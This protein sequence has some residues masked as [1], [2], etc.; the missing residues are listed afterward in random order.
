MCGLLQREDVRLLTLTGPGGTGKTRMG[1]QVAANL[2]EDFE[3]GVY[4]VPLAAINDP[5][6]VVS[7]IAQVL[8]IREKAGQ[9][10][11]DSLKEYLQAKQILLVLDNFEQVVAAAPLVAELLATCRRLPALVTSRVVLRLSGEHEFPV[12]P[13][14]SLILDICPPSRLYHSMPQ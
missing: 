1:L 5:A 12:P 7:T 9:L 4:F 10:L 8:G 14:T 6:L 13:W 11:L 3:S 2:L